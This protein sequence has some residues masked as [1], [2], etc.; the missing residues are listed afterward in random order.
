MT[1]I[2]KPRTPSSS[3]NLQKFSIRKLYDASKK[4]KNTENS[5]I[6]TAAGLLQRLAQ[7]QAWEANDSIKAS[8]YIVSLFSGSNL[9]ETFVLVPGQLILDSINK[10]IEMT[11]DQEKQNWEQA[12]KT[13]S[14]MMERG[15]EFFIIDGQNRLFLAINRFISNKFPISHEHNLILD[16]LNEDGT[17]YEFNAKGKLFKEFPI[18]IQNYFYDHIR[19]PVNIADSGTLESFCSTLIWKNESIAWDEWQKTITKQ[20]FSPFLKQIREISD[21]DTMHPNILNCFRK[22]GTA[23]YGY[24]VN[25]WDFLVAELL[26]L[27]ATGRLIQS[28]KDFDQFFTGRQVVP[29]SLVRKLNSYLNDFSK[30]WKNK[31]KITNTEIKNYVLIRN[32]LDRPNSSSLY[33][34]VNIPSWNLNDNISFSKQCKIMFEVLSGEPEKYGQPPNRIQT[35]AGGKTVSSKNPGGYQDLNGKNSDDSL[36]ARATMFFSILTGDNGHSGTKKVFEHLSDENIIS[37]KDS[38]PMSSTASIWTSSPFS[39]DGE[40]I[41]VVDYD[42]TKTFDRGHIIPQS[43]GGSN[44][45]LVLQKKSQ[46]RKLKDSPIT[47]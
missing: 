11:S 39:A 32:L 15:T 13:I 18:E 30:A 41:S 28:E 44:T 9:L 42:D 7:W 5:T 31:S 20:W 14:D 38:N 45:D 12:K 21:K 25:G 2:V 22:L 16:V 47:E 3:F 8:E 33:S 23:K 27:M 43:L 10:N 36:V 19:V 1:P 6:G 26:Y 24:E 34:N 46:N 17:F 40:E 37:V 35:T 4:G 29:K